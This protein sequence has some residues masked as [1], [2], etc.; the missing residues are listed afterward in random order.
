MNRTYAL[1]TG[2]LL[3]TFGAF[4]QSAAPA[5]NN[6]EKDQT[7]T[8]IEKLPTTN[9]PRTEDLHFVDLMAETKTIKN[10]PYTADEVTESTQIL[11]DGNRIVKKTT[12]S[13]A[14]DGQGRTRREESGIAL[15]GLRGNGPKIVTIY[16]PVAHAQYVFQPG[17]PSAS[18]AVT[19][20]LGEGA[21]TGV[22]SGSEFPHGFPQKVRVFNLSRNDATG[23]VEYGTTNERGTRTYFTVEER[24]EAD[25]VKRESLG[26]QVIDGITAEGTRETRTIPAGAIGNEKPIVITVERWTSPDLQTVILSKRNDPRFGETV[27]KL[28]DITRGEPDPSLFQPPGNVKKAIPVR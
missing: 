15:G 23:N 12:A 8:F 9:A 18:G 21:G 16:D 4:A 10:A 24:P 27:Y 7:F 26:T 11:S 1:I 20:S 5:K 6:Q 28:T 19:R 13:V 14:R 22:G 3:L 2:I 17:D 25:D